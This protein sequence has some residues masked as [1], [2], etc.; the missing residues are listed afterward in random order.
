[1][2]WAVS[3]VIEDG[4]FNLP[5]GFVWVCM[6]KHTY[7]II[8]EGRHPPPPKKNNITI[9]PNVANYW[10]LFDINQPHHMLYNNR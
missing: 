6:G 2:D 9:F 10:H 7:F 4:H 1:M 3:L 8:Q 5:Q